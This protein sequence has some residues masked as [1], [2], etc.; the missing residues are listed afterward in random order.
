MLILKLLISATGE[1]ACAPLWRN[2][3]H[4]RGF[5]GDVRRKV[6]EQSRLQRAAESARAPGERDLDPPGVAQFDWFQEVV[7]RVLA[8]VYVTNGNRKRKRPNGPDA[9]SNEIF[10]C[11]TMFSG[12]IDERAWCH[13]NKPPGRCGRRDGEYAILVVSRIGK[14]DPTMYWLPTA[15]WTFV[16]AAIG[17]DAS[18]KRDSVCPLVHA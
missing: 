15:D 4:G 3:R 10:A 7:D 16:R 13:A 17:K 9:R 6:R 5:Q 11:R 2:V 14:D 8:W 12:S 18:R 1:A